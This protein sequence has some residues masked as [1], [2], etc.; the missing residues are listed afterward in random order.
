[1]NKESKELIEVKTKEKKIHKFINKFIEVIKKKW[2]I[3]GTKTVILV[4][5]ILAIFLTINIVMK[6]LDLTPID[7]SQDKLY[8]LSDDSKRLV[9]NIAKTV[10][11][12]FVEYSE[13]DT[14]IDLAKQ[15]TKVNDNISIEELI[16]NN[17]INK[18]MPDHNISIEVAKANDRPDLVQKYGIET[19]ASGIIVECGDKYKVLSPDELVTFNNSSFETV[20][21]SEEKLTASLLLVTAEIVPKVYFLTGYSNLSLQN[22]LQYLNV[23]LQN[24]INEVK[25]VDILAT[26][27]VPEDCDTLVIVMPAKDFEESVTNAILEYINKGGNILWFQNA[28]AQ[29]MDLPNVNKILATYGIKPFE[30]GVIRETDENKM[31]SKM[32]DYILPDIENTVVTRKLQNSG[33]I[34]LLDATKINTEEDSKLDELKVQKTELV[35][36]SENSYFRSNFY[37]TSNEP[38]EGEEKKSYTIGQMME[39]TITEANEETGERAK[40]SKLIIYGEG[41]FISD[42]PLSTGGGD[43]VIIYRQNRDVAIDS[44]AY[45]SNK[46]E[47]V[48]SRKRTGTVTYSATETENNVILVIIFAVPI[49]I[50]ISGIIVWIVRRRRK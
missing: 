33:G 11:M 32:P 5:I 28:I 48:I 4:A 35:K 3:N 18:M 44:I 30:I 47:G 42:I 50:I 15:Y 41:Y 13:D 34:I 38:Q 24:D 12:Y 8:T 26:E 40:V 7:L 6:S 17:D 27:K 37:L 29:N 1:M 36:S 39:K 43:P 45:L 19:G 23:Y 49:I 20:D 21:V 2:L 31:L 16:K 9:K 25:S 46:S 10:K 22:G 14:I